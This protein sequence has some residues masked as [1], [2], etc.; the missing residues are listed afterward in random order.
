MHHFRYGGCLNRTWASFFDAMLC[1]LLYPLLSFVIPFEYVITVLTTAHIAYDVFFITKYGKTP[2][3][4]LAKLK[5]VCDE[6]TA[7][8]WPRALL[9]TC[10]LNCFGLLGFAYMG[11]KA[12]PKIVLVF[13][14][15]SM[16]GTTAQ[17]L[18]YLLDPKRRMLHDLLSG[19][20]VLAMNKPLLVNERVFYW[21]KQ[22]VARALLI[23]FSLVGGGA[24]TYYSV[25]LLRHLYSSSAMVTTFHLA[26]MECL[27]E[28]APAI[29]APDHPNAKS[30]QP[31][32]TNLKKYGKRGEAELIGLSNNM[33][34][35]ESSETFTVVFQV[36]YGEKTI[37]EKG[38]YH[39]TSSGK[40]SLESLEVSELDNAPHPK[41]SP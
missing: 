20:V 38:T 27:S 31:I 18:S 3:M 16:V 7:V 15:I 19:T 21:E 28:K 29:C 35:G 34:R 12:S 33:G 24:C 10:A 37:V 2:G 6:G 40:L 41:A 17:V 36:R 32:I 5:L 39:F 26:F 30:L 11:P 1:G 22:P 25:K 23:V 13:V 4:H 14:A 9:R 8:P